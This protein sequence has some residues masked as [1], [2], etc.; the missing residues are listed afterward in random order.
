MQNVFSHL[1]GKG[2]DRVPEIIFWHI[3][4]HAYKHVA[5]RFCSHKNCVGSMFREKV[6]AQ[7]AELGMMKLIEKRSS[8][9]VTKI[10]E[11]FFSLHSSSF[12]SFL[13]QSHI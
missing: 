5:P 12:S 8:V 13:P 10:E 7:E 2:F 1:K 6:A 9:K 4:S 11:L 3:P